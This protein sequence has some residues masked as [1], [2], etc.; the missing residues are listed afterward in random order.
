MDQVDFDSCIESINSEADICA[1]RP[2]RLIHAWRLWVERLSGLLSVGQEEADNRMFGAVLAEC[3]DPSAPPTETRAVWI[4]SVIL[5]LV[6]ADPQFATES[7]LMLSD[8]LVKI[9][10]Q[11]KMNGSEL[12]PFQPILLRIA[13]SYA[14]LESQGN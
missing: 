2:E 1:V 8:K 3:V 6:L 4:R 7:P 10:A 14:A 13:S 5:R 12:L 11:I 9:V